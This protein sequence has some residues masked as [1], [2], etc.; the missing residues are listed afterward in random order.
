M[1]GDRAVP[2]LPVRDLVV[3]REFY[4]AFGFECTYLDDGWMILDR[5]PLRLEFY[6]WREHNPATTASRCTIRVANVDELAD[7]IRGSGVPVH[8][9]GI[10]RFEPVTMQTWGLRAGNLIDPDG[11]LVVLIEEPV[12]PAVAR[13]VRR[14]RP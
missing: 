1:N 3:A 2:N 6:E 9:W 4:G 13:W 5:G 12:E 7:A 8:P 14:L 10:P 11:N